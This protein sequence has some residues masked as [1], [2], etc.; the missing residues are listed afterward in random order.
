MVSRQK[1]WGISSAA[2]FRQKILSGFLRMLSL[3]IS[4]YP[5]RCDNL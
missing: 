5:K 2:E 4:S 1:L 3:E